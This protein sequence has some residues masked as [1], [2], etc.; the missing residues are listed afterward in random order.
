MKKR[1]IALLLLASLVPISGKTQCLPSSNG[2]NCGAISP[3]QSATGSTTIC[4]SA[5]SANR[6]ITFNYTTAILVD[7]V[8]IDFGDN[9]F[10]T[11]IPTST[12]ITFTHT[13]S[14]PQTDFCPS[15]F[16]QPPVIFDVVANFY[17]SCS[18]QFSF[19]KVAQQV[20]VIFD[21]RPKIASISSQCINDMTCITVGACTGLSGTSLCSCT[22]ADFQHPGS[23]TWDFGDGTSQSFNNV[24]DNLYQDICH[25]YA[26]GGTYTITLSA[27]N[28]CGTRTDSKPNLH[29]VK[30]DTLQISGLGHNCTGDTVTLNL[31]GSGGGGTYFTS[32]TP[33][34]LVNDANT[35]HPSIRFDSAGI[36]RIRVS[37]GPCTIDSLIEIFPGVN[38]SQ[39]DIPDSCFYGSFTL[40]LSQY[41]ITNNF[42]Q[43]NTA[44]ITKNG[45]PV[46]SG[47]LTLATLSDTGMYTVA[48]SCST[49][50]NTANY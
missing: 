29:F 20:T 14:Y 12:S 18:G 21:P 45:T 34:V 15:G 35:N 16:G 46:W 10:S 41:Y 9:N 31:T 36:Y 43:V 39:V 6:T 27:T 32:V 24:T 38:M 30:V 48:V 50:C 1:I 3:T 23:Y 4:A 47:G 22:N 25:T 13:Y 19:D 7:Q 26:S 11:I 5:T 42:N 40:D 17:K 8:C 28:I 49:S 37:Y 2:S 44:T 33:S